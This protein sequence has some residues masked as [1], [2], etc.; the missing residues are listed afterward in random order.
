VGIDFALTEVVHCKSRQQEGVA[1]ALECCSER[2]LDRVLS[3]SVAHVTI[4]YGEPAKRAVYRKY[5]SGMMKWLLPEKLAEFHIAAK[6]RILIFLP[7][8]NERGSEKTLIA[9]IGTEGISIVRSYLASR[10][11]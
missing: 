4:V 1:D 2:F 5:G 6:P 7:A 3:I 10:A 11:D 8:P 9:N